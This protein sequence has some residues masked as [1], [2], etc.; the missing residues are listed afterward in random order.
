[1]KYKDK[2]NTH[3]KVLILFISAIILMLIIAIIIGAIAA[4]QK[5]MKRKIK[6]TLDNKT[7]EG[8]VEIRNLDHFNVQRTTRANIFKDRTKYTRKK[9]H[10]NKED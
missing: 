1:M 9:K 7:I 10:K 8:E 6:I 2:L 3:I 5:T 4:Q